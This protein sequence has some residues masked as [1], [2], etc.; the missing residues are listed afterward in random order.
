MKKFTLALSVICA[1]SAFAQDIPDFIDEVP[2][3]ETTHETEF[4]NI[5]NS[6]GKCPKSIKLNKEI[7]FLDPQVSLVKTTFD[8]KKYV[9]SSTSLNGEYYA[10]YNADLKSKYSNC[11]A[12]VFFSDFTRVR[13]LTMKNG[14]LRIIVKEKSEGIMEVEFSN[15][16]NYNN[17]FIVETAEILPYLP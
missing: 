4:V 6:T 17:Q 10:E 12:D 8:I 11:S 14:N 13:R 3:P 16:S 1:S 5:N 9:T 7:T 2:M 15:V